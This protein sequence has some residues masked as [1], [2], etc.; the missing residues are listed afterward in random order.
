VAAPEDSTAASAGPNRNDQ[1]R[2][3][4]RIIGEFQRRGHISSHWTSDQQ[5]IGV[6]RGRNEV[7]SEALQVVVGVGEG[8]DFCF[9]AITRAGIDL[10]DIQRSP[11]QRTNL[12]CCPR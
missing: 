11:D 7:N 5:H 12:F 10:P 2:R 3:R 8:D 6:L 4:N 9:A 1:L